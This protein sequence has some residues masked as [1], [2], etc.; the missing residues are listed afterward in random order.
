MTEETEG[1]AGGSANTFG[2]LDLDVTPATVTFDLVR[3]DPPALLLSHPLT[4]SWI[5][6][7][8]DAQ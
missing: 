5:R 3:F 4:A 8:R 6:A 2:T 7:R 1:V